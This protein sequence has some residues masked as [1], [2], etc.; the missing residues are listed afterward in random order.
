MVGSWKIDVVTGGMPQKVATAFAECTEKLIGAE[1][2]PIAY[3]GSQIVNGINHAIL[4]EQ[5]VLTGKDTK[6][7]V[8]MIFNEKDMGC[9]LVNIER[10]VEGGLEFGGTK[11][12]VKTDIP[13]GAKAV[14]D[15]VISGFVGS[16]VK[17]FALL[18]TQI[19]KGTD[20]IF[21][22]TVIPVAPDAEPKLALVTVN[23][24]TNGITFIDI[25]N[26]PLNNLGYAFTWVTLNKPLG[27]WP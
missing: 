24:M 22:A 25:L 14:F 27:E 13:A 12:D 18:G 4:A 3:V 20:Y 10:I 19:T 6:N 2:T 5:T 7:I 26:A 21:A 15:S 8:L 9:T 23:P 11:I 17:P 1:Y 16:L